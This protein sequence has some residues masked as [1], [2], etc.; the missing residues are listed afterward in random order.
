MGMRRNL[1]APY[2]DSSKYLTKAMNGYFRDAAGLSS[3]AARPGLTTGN[4]PSAQMGTGQRGQ[5]EHS[6]V[7]PA[8]GAIYRFFAVNGKLYRSNAAFTVFTDVSPVGI[9]IDNAA[10]TR[11]SMLSVGA[12]MVAT[13]GVN[14]PWVASNFASTPIT[15]TYIDIDGAGGAWSTWGKPTTYQDSVMWITQT[16][17]S[18]SDVQARIG[19]VWSEPNQPAVGYDQPGY[20]D[21]WNMIETSSDPL[22]C[23]LGTNDGLFV[24]RENSITLATGTPSI[25]FSSTASREARGDSVGSVTPWAVAIFGENIFF[26]DNL[27]R[28]WMMPLDGHPQPIWEQLAS[29]TATNGVWG[30]GTAVFGYIATGTIVPELNLYLVAISPGNSNASPKIGEVFDAGSG[31]Y[32][33]EWNVASGDGSF[34]VIDT[35]LDANGARVLS[36]MGGIGGGP[37]IQGGYVSI[38]SLSGLVWTDSANGLMDLRIQ[39]EPI[40]FSASYVMH[41]DYA[42]IMLRTPDTIPVV[43]YF[44]AYGNPPSVLNVVPLEPQSTAVIQSARAVVGLDGAATRFTQFYFT[45]PTAPV[46]Q[47]GLQRIE[48]FGSRSLAGPDDA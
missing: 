13:D 28:P 47:W 22:Y 46:S 39:T 15:G 10:S 5:G 42:N 25:N 32:A 19:F 3:W 17:P 4:Y 12:S 44:A 8:T 40:G 27:G 37:P 26:L 16:V 11:V 7:D 35:M 1:D 30:A 29:V 43:G 48:V 36:V 23:L 2:T 31:A 14:R 21:F 20:A 38:L 18:G 9:T 34:D 6:H 24:W 33:G 41:P 45:G